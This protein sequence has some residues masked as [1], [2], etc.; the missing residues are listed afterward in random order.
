[1]KVFSSQQIRQ[2]D[3]Y[4][5]EHE[6]ISSINLMER[7]SKSFVDLF[8]SLIK[9]KIPITIIAGTGNNGGD[10][11]AIA[12]ILHDNDYPIQLFLLQAAKFSDDYLINL[13]RLPRSI[14]KTKIEQEVP[15]FFPGTI[16]IDGL[17]GSG[18]NR[19][20]TGIAA[21]VIQKINSSKSEV[22]AIDIPSGMLSDGP[23]FGSVVQADYT[24]TFQ[25]PKLGFLM[26]ENEKYVGQ[27]KVA[28]IGLDEKYLS[29]LSTPYHLST[30]PEIDQFFP[31]RKRFSHKGEFGHALIAG[32]SLG[33]MG[34]V[35]LACKSALRTGAGL[36][37]ARVPGHG[38]EI[39]Q[40][41]FP[42][43]MSIPDKNINHLEHPIDAS[44]FKSIGIGPGMGVEAPTVQFMKKMLE[45]TNQLLVL[46]ADALNILSENRE[47][48]HLISKRAILTPHPGEFKRLFG[49]TNND[50][51]R[52]ALLRSSA[53]KYQVVIVLKGAFSAIAG[54]DGVVYFNTTGN[55]GMSTA[56]SGDVLTGIITALL[57]LGIPLL[58]SARLGVYLHGKSG[59][60]AKIEKGEWSMIAGDLIEYLPLAI[61]QLTK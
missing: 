13:K 4:T 26:P 61:K 35:I 12:R 14:K 6:P 38:N 3:A 33:K 36:V 58:E 15:E 60:F 41:A 53:I 57:A 59:D 47:L 30:E 8:L 16:I 37:S 23:S 5:I 31:K 43:A 1:M 20:V 40:S 9:K 49:S 56:G 29:S 19:E 18:L 34:A 2:A 55:S 39:I 44:L 21:E 27:W 50:F 45:N 46:D 7:A 24:I 52:L 22:F 54:P 42:E 28:E 32:G 51:E 11:L 10:A 48:F 17:F 25:A